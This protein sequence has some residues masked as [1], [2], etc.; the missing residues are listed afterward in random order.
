MEFRG[1]YFMER[2]IYRTAVKKKKKIEGKRIVEAPAE[3]SYV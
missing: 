2:I 1:P 3:S